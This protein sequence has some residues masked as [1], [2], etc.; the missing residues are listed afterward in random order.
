SEECSGR[1]GP[2][3]RACEGA[4]RREQDRARQAEG[5]GRVREVSVEH[6]RG[7][8][9]PEAARGDGRRG[10]L[11]VVIGVNDSGEGLTQAERAQEGAGGE[12]GDAGTGPRT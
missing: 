5:D 1:Q 11:G 6:R 10:G 3:T 8:R 12:E 7:A 4:R 9:G 2:S